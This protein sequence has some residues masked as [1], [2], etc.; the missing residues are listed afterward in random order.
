M[1][2]LEKLLEGQFLPVK[3]DYLTAK[4]VYDATPIGFYDADEGVEYNL[5]VW[6]ATSKTDPS[7]EEREY[8]ATVTRDGFV[9]ALKPCRACTNILILREHPVTDEQIHKYYRCFVAE[10]GTRKKCLNCILFKRKEC[11]LEQEQDKVSEMDVEEIGTQ[12]SEGM[13]G[14]SIQDVPTVSAVSA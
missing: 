8:H 9:E 1:R 12:V 7:G 10:S 5:R 13:E 6:P 3:T 2:Q 4:R 11:N 14:L